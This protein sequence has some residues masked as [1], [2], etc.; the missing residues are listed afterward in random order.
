MSD[1]DTE[2]RGGRAV[3]TGRIARMTRLGA[4][5]G[6][7]AGGVVAQ[8]VL[9]LAR[10]RRPNMADLVLT[11]A[12]ARRLT[13]QLSHLRGA[14]MK[15]GQ[16][17]SLDAGDMLPPE[18][19]AI[20][21]TLRDG[22]Q[23]MPPKQLRGVLDAAWGAGWMRRF[24]RFDV[25]PIASAS[26]GQVHRARTLDGR[27][28]A[29]KLQYP[30]VA[31][32][33]DSDLDNVTT[34]LRLSGMVPRDVDFSPLLDEAR[35]QLHE[36]ADY[37][38]E[39]DYL[40]RFGAHLADDPDFRVP[41]LHADFCTPSVLA[42]E[43]IESTPIEAV[44]DAPQAERDRVAQALIT[45]TLREMF[46]FRL[47]QTDPNFA[48]Y[49][50]DAGS[51]QIVL[52]DFGA[53][54]GFDAAM[55]GQYR[56]LLRAG[57]VQ[58]RVAV[59]IAMIDIGYFDASAAQAHQDLLLDMFDLACEALRQDTPFDFGTTDLIVRMRDMGMVLG[60][61]REFWHVPPAELLFLHRKI[62]GMFLLAARLRARVALGPLVAAYADVN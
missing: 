15:L 31:A 46:D 42:M 37:T 2:F 60:G 59:R 23:P 11:P 22:A 1:F 28:L 56:A 54:R 47:M 34:L 39:A 38:R 44:A 41:A 17:L 62:G 14:A 18:L 24:S 58:D 7:L 21:A 45:L 26:I 20:M 9:Q 29:I 32:S 43:F 12:N 48:N 35:R 36:E 19:T 40:A 10:G 8:G 33:I 50:Y 27:D 53:A 4:L 55:A 51:R 52:L 6:G 16:M 57:L 61:E 49:R 5:A 3:P 30:G 25:R 13:A